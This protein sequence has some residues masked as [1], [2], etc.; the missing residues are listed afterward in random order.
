MLDRPIWWPV[1][2]N[3][4]IFKDDVVVDGYR[5]KQPIKI[6]YTPRWSYKLLFQKD[7][8][9]YKYSSN[10][11][12][13]IYIILQ[14]NVCNLTKIGKTRLL[15]AFNT[16]KCTMSTILF[17]NNMNRTM[18]SFCTKWNSFFSLGDGGT[19]RYKYFFTKVANMAGW[20]TCMGCIKE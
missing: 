8:E 3:V 7:K 12:H 4:V 19:E 14:W 6:S 9:I 10:L 1:T 11:K 5:W 20:L 18:L 2:I 17:D 16:N 13:G 15:L